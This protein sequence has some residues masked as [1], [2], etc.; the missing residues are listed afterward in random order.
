[1]MMPAWGGDK[2]ER[3]LLYPEMSMSVP[4]AKF[5]W[6]LSFLAIVIII[7]LKFEQ[8]PIAL[9]DVTTIAV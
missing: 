4:R 7:K 3:T 1:M 6:M 8:L 2:R 9:D 5:G